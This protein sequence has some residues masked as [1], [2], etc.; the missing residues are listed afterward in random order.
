MSSQ[1]RWRNRA[2]LGAMV[3]MALV[4]PASAQ[5]T[6]DI[7]AEAPL[8]YIVR[9]GD[10]LY[11]LARNYLNRPSDYREL[12]RENRV[13]NPRRMP[14]GRSLDI[15]VQLLRT[16]PDRALLE[17]YRG[18]VQVLR[19]T[20]PQM[21]VRGLTL[22]EGD[23]ITTGN[24]SFARIALSDG[25]YAVVPS[26]SRIRLERLRRYEINNE[27]DH[28]LSVQSGRL[29]NSVN[30]RQRPGTYRVTTPSAVSAVRGT[31][32]RVSY[33]EALET[34]SLGVLEGSVATAAIAGGAAELNTAGQGSLTVL[35]AE[36][37]ITAVLLA[38][39]ALVAPEKIQTGPV[40]VF[41][42][43]PAPETKLV[44]GV[45][46]ND[47]GMTDPVAEL[48]TTSTSLT[49]DELD[50]GRWFIRLSGTSAEGLEGRPRTYDFIRAR[51]GVEG[52]ALTQG[53]EDSLRTYRFAWRGVGQGEASFRFQI[54]QVDADGNRVGPYLIDKPALSENNYTLTDL[55]TGDY[56]WR[57]ES[58]R[59]RFGH[60]LSAWSE[61][62]QLTISR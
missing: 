20:N 5:A 43:L 6:N 23:V 40:L 4:T 41:D 12:Q 1:S 25:S 35:G 49:L 24:N 13:A 60:R 42:T 31:E 56:Q 2:A 19:D 33:N 15:P 47:A 9:A 28:Q 45:I 61:P 10:N 54:W 55:P 21:L 29:Q 46:G 53:H 48:E 8:T 51:N 52:L 26:N 59:Y 36:G 57:V 27:P 18:Q 34:G 11:T 14:T 7:L 39:P 62:E 58:V 44:R 17:S 50:E 38:A 16:R 37:V 30:P 32:F 3:G 22:T